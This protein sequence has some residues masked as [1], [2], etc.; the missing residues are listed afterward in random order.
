MNKTWT[1]TSST[2]F[3]FNV[4][5]GCDLSDRCSWTWRGW[6]SNHLRLTQPWIFTLSL[7]TSLYC[8]DFFSIV[9][10]FFCIHWWSFVQ[11]GWGAPVSCEVA[12]FC[13][14]ALEGEDPELCAEEPWRGWWGLI[15]I[16]WQEWLKKRT[17]IQHWGLSFFVN[18]MML[19]HWFWGGW[20]GVGFW[21]TLKNVNL[22]AASNFSQGIGKARTLIDQKSQVSNLSRWEIWG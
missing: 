4:G 16:I 2:C 8:K 12:F 15:W 13:N 10:I 21:S 11:P 5:F 7:V 9:S 20:I 1:K 18:V 3:S 19:F 14:C 6:V 17:A 22:Q